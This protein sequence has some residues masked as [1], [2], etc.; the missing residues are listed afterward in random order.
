MSSVVNFGKY[1]LCPN[2]EG[3]GGCDYCLLLILQEI[4]SKMCNLGSSLDDALLTDFGGLMLRFSLQ[5]S[6]VHGTCAISACDL[7]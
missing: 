4:V 2:I 7:V 5:G 6:W 1:Y 3:I